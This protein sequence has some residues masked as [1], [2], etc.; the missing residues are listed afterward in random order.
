MY[1]SEVN[2]MVERGQLAYDTDAFEHRN[3]PFPYS[4]LPSVLEAGIAKVVG[5]LRIAQ[6]FCHFFFPAA[7]AWFMIEM[8]S[9]L[10]STTA[11]ASLLSLAVMVF[12]F[13]L[14]T[15]IDGNIS[16]VSRGLASGFIETLQAARNPHPNITFFHFL[17]TGICATYAVKR[18]SVSLAV[19]AGILG[20]LL[21]YAYSFYAIAWT[22]GC[23]ILSALAFLPSLKIPKCIGFALVSDAVV[24]APYFVWMHASKLSGGYTNRAMRLG[25]IQS[26]LPSKLGLELT[27]IYA[28]F[29]VLVVAIWRFSRRDNSGNVAGARSSEE[30]NAA[31]SV[32]ICMALGGI[33][34]MNMQVITGFNIEPEHHF[35]HMVI[36]PVSLIVAALLV[37]HLLVRPETRG[38]ASRISHNALVLLFLF[39]AIAQ[40]NS[41]YNSAEFHRIKPSDRQLFDWLKQGSAVADVVATTNMRLNITIP[42]FTHNDILVANGS[43]SSGT[44]AELVERF[45]VANALSGT[46]ST[47]LKRELT[48]T[49]NDRSRGSRPL[50]WTYSYYMFEHSPYFNIA[51]GNIQPGYLPIVLAKYDDVRAHLPEELQKFRVDFVFVSNAQM[52]PA[53][54]GW[55]MQAVLGTQDGT[56][57]RLRRKPVAISQLHLSPEGTAT[58]HG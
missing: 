50:Q 42:D 20:G 35:P 2:Y 17:C 30:F 58:A 19:T 41:G 51:E 15:L 9:S 57:W 11:L 38:K 31:F 12:G 52:P 55:Q 7:T 39:C 45:L 53:I 28:A 40:A 16:L 6:I 4:V 34:G 44:D 49:Y 21:F 36:Q 33:C 54:S 24:A 43:R 25:M 23:I 48:E 13:S 56:L 18:R 1:V 26:H 22:L 46:S 3:E 29:L 14:R 32:W 8:F 37:L 10:G 47:E 27:L 5:D